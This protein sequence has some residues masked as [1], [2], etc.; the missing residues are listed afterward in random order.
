M[1]APPAV[2]QQQFL[3]IE[4]KL[5]NQE[6]VISVKAERVQPLTITRAETSSHDFY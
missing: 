5:Q 3:L 4:G 2:V 1:S 6:G